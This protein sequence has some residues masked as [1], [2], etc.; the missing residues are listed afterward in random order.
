MLRNSC[1]GGGLKSLSQ[2]RSHDGLGKGRCDQHL[3]M[4]ESGKYRV[5]WSSDLSTST[6]GHEIHSCVLQG[7]ESLCTQDAGKETYGAVH[8][9]RKI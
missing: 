8:F 4:Q 3:A 6:P 1:A 7:E 5:R 2:Y 9:W